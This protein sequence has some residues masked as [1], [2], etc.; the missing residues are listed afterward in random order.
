MLI[1]LAK[2]LVKI[3]LPNS[4]IEARKYLM[5]IEIYKMVAIIN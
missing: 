2:F 5:E 3:G 1:K 4:S